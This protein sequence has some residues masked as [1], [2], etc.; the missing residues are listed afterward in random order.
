MTPQEIRKFVNQPTPRKISISIWRV[1]A[2]SWRTGIWTLTQHNLYCL[3]VLFLLL[4]LFCCYL[5]A[6]WALPVGLFLILSSISWLLVHFIYG[7]SR[8]KLKRILKWGEFFS[9]PINEIECSFSSSFGTIACMK[10]RGM[11]E[12][13]LVRTEAKA[14]RTYITTTKERSVGLLYLERTGTV[15]TDLWL[16]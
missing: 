5:Y 3:W 8:W 1:A 10:K 14:L 2:R 7:F 4:G 6:I 15:I 16:E 13:V 9:Y 11:T 12:L